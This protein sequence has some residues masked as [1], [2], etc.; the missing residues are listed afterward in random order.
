MNNAVKNI[1]DIVYKGKCEDCKDHYPN[2]S[3]RV[4]SRG[5]LHSWKKRH[6]EKT[7]HTVLT[8]VTNV[9]R[10]PGKESHA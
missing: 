10:Y 8:A 2:K 3:T 4:K 9:R 5:A 7:G 1:I 6:Q